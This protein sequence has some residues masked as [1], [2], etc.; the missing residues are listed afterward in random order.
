MFSLTCGGYK[1]YHVF[2]NTNGI[3][4][5]AGMAVP[6]PNQPFQMGAPG[7]TEGSRNRKRH[8]KKKQGTKTTKI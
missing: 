4:Q 7:G 8:V 2:I 3:P 5:S 6:M 1:K